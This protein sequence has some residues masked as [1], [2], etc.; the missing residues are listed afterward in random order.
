G[1]CGSTASAP[2]SDF[3]SSLRNRYVRRQLQLRVA[4]LAGDQVFG[5]GDFDQ[6]DGGALS[7][8]FQLWDRVG[9]ADGVFGHGGV[10]LGFGQLGGAAGGF[11]EGFV[12]EAAAAPRAQER[13]PTRS[14]ADGGEGFFGG[15]VTGDV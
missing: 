10:E 3:T 13:G 7:H 11:D 4:L 14:V 6:I 8:L 2:Q 15:A 12:V 5:D 1:C 9:L